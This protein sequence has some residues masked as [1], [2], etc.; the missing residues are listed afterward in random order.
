MTVAQLSSNILRWLAYLILAVALAWYA[1][2]SARYHSFGAI[3]N[4]PATYTQMALDLAARGTPTHEFSLLNNLT[5]LGASREAFIPVGYHRV[6]GS[7]ATAPN[8]AFG[9]PLLMAAAYR[10]FGAS[11]LDW[12]TP[13]LGAGAL[14]AAYALGNELFAELAEWQRRLVSALA[15]LLL[16]TTPKQ[17]QLV[18]VPMSDVPA[19][20]FCILTVLFALLTLRQ[21]AES[22]AASSGRATGASVLFAA[23][24]GASLGM[25]YLVRHSMLVMLLPLAVIAPRWGARGRMR[26]LLSA[27]AL[28]AFVLVV[29]PD[30]AYHVTVLGGLLSVESAESAQVSLANAPLQFVA[31]FGAL[32][33]VTG[34][35]PVLVMALAGVWAAFREKQ[36]FALYVLGAWIL[37]FMLLHAPLVLTG[38]FE[39]NLRY[40]VPA[41]PALALLTSLGIVYVCAA[42]VRGVRAHF[43]RGR[44]VSQFP[45]TLGA[46]AA[47]L[48]ALALLAIALRAL[49]SPE[50][51]AARAYGRM[52]SVARADINALNAALPANAVIGASDQMAGALGLYTAHEVF[53]PGAMQSA[54]FARLVQTLREENK[55]VALVG[56][57]DCAPQGGAS[58]QLPAWM[59]EYPA[60]EITGALR[61]LPYECAQKVRLLE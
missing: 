18:L 46:I 16:A 57:W 22:A 41:Y 25:A 56:D 44:S 10:L 26:W 59:A 42:A 7:D 27:A 50:R 31:L 32:L 21:G 45:R 2:L 14:L 61:E 54:E 23:L 51:F 47:A 60:R 29:V 43:A 24:C 52:T 8:F 38:V 19:Q 9:L 13:L 28:G 4:D 58:E 20:L 48:V 17:I 1:G 55:S 33:A 40:L 49:S 11:A 36:R 37:G 3:G 15:V 35:G 6:P 53:R 5:D 12:V 30:L 39:N 34:F